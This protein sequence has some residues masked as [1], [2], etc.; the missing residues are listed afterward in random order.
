MEEERRE[1]RDESERKRWRKRTEKRNAGR[2]GSWS[3]AHRIR[4]LRKE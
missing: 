2:G 4:K 1:G 3:T